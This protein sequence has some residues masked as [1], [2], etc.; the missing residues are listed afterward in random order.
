MLGSVENPKVEL[1]GKETC[2][3]VN[4]VAGIPFVDVS[5]ISVNG[6]DGPEVVTDSDTS[7]VLCVASACVVGNNV[8][9]IT[10]VETASA[11]NRNE[12]KSYG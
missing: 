11:P 10:E 7:G 6:P 4:T 2:S 5:D 1:V 9:V 12:N 3:E 8:S